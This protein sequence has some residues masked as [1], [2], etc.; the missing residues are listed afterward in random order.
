MA[1]EEATAEDGVWEGEAATEPAAKR[2]GSPVVVGRG[3]DAAVSGHW[4]CIGGP[5][6]GVW[7][8]RGVSNLQQDVAGGLPVLRPLPCCLR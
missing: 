7:H 3:G 6:I 2:E 5:L 8:S 1:M 4:C